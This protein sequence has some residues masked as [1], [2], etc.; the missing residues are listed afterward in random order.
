MT[1]MGLRVE[2][3]LSP[4]TW[5]RF[6]NLTSTCRDGAVLQ[7]DNPSPRHVETQ[8]QAMEVAG[9]VYRSIG[10]WWLTQTG[11]QVA[12]DLRGGA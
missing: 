9:L 6:V 1:T 4:A 7:V 5:A 2:L 3:K 10:G 12:S 8:M 11:N